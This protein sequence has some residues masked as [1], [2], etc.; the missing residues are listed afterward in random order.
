M[1]Q[2]WAKEKDAAGL[3]HLD[4]EMCTTTYCRFRTDTMTSILPDAPEAKSGWKTKNHYF[5]EVVNNLRTR[6]KNGPKGNLVSMQLALSAKNIPS[7]LREICDRIDEQY[8]SKRRYKNW[9]WR[10]PFGAQRFVV[11][12]DMDEEEIIAKLNAQFDELM[13]FEKDLLQVMGSQ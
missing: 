8:P 11:P 5:Y 7:D 6:V 9:A 1:I 2:K 3:I 10:I 12:Y 13:N 4:M